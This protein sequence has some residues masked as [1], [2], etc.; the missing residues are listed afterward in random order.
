MILKIIP[1]IVVVGLGVYTTTIDRKDIHKE[2]LLESQ[3]DSLNHSIQGQIIEIET[4]ERLV[5]NERALVKESKVRE[6]SI[7]QQKKRIHAYYI[8]DRKR[9]TNVADSSFSS[10]FTELINNH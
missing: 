1:W 7:I 5:I 3:I 6:D 9:I 4:L 2:K 8:K 10:F